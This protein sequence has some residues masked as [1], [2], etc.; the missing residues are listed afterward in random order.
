VAEGG[1]RA[2]AG[3]ESRVVAHG[4]QAR[5]DR[6]DQLLL[7]AALEVPAPHGAFEQDVADQRELRGGVVEDHVARRM[8]GT[9]SDVEGQ[10]ADGRLIAII[11]PAGGL[12]GA[13]GDPVLCAVAFKPLDPETVILMRSFDLDAELF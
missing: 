5:P 6:S 10:F 11:E 1:H 8:A 13:S 9:M 12:E 2:V 3:N 7:I 4:P